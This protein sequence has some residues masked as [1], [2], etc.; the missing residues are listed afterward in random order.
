MPN[1]PIPPWL[2]QTDPVSSYTRGLQIGSQI[3][4]EQAAQQ[5]HQ[6]ANA[7]EEQKAAIQ[8]EI[9]N[10]KLHL[11]A[12]VQA[13]KYSAHIK[14]Q[15]FVDGG[16]DPIQG[17]LRFGPEMGVTGAGLS[18][19]AR[20]AHP[21]GLNVTEQDGEK[22]LQTSPNSYSH[23]PRERAPA[24]VKPQVHFNSDGTVSVFDPENGLTTIGTSKPTK[25]GKARYTFHKDNGD[26]VSGTVDDPAIADLVKKAQ[27]AAKQS[28]N[29]E[30]ASTGFH[31]IDALTRFLKGTPA[32]TSTNAAPFKILGIRKK[33]EAAPAQDLATD[34]GPN[35]TPP[36]DEQDQTDDGD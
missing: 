10:A 2:T 11:A 12:D 27:D 20:E 29:T 6:Q 7:R 14:Y 25:T 1:Y 17:L 19:L 33:G 18:Q 36:T 35:S 30:T 21:F 9:Q 3:G 13:R 26:I 28:E 8:A 4:S 24:P 34:D 5:L 22:Y 23:V 16:G 31:P 15:Q 32:P